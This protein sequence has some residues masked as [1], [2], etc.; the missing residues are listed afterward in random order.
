MNNNLHNYIPIFYQDWWL[1]AVRQDGEV[2]IHK[3]GGE[4]MHLHFPI[5]FKRI[6]GIKKIGLPVLTPYLGPYFTSEL[7]ELKEHRRLGIETSL[8]EQA[9]NLNPWSPSYYCTL[10][11]DK[12][13]NLMPFLNARFKAF[14]QI[15]YRLNVQNLDTTYAQFSS[16]VRNKISKA[17][18]VSYIKESSDTDLL[19]HLYQKSIDRK[20]APL[21]LT[22]GT[23][24]KVF[25]VCQLKNQGKI[26][27]SY[28]DK[29]EP[30]AGCFLV[31]DDHCLYT[32]LR[33]GSG[34]SLSVGAMSSLI[35]ECIKIAH[36]KN[37]VMDFV[38]SSVP[39]IEKFVRY[40]GGVQTFYPGLRKSLF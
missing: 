39:P 11:P 8:I 4:N 38:G 16:S 32:V 13:C 10:H 24:K 40:F 22:Q 1:D 36:E 30:I 28:N 12:V 34:S 19:Y 3:L 6:L 7:T 15:T 25:Q 18:T 35:W 33:G 27:L 2:I 20:Q 37:L 17:Q 29:D 5:Y 9:L 21:S 23:L 31:W 26:L 14:V